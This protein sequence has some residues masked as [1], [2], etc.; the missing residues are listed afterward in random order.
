MSPCLF[1]IYLYQYLLLYILGSLLHIL[2]LWGGLQQLKELIDLH[3]RLM[4]DDTPQHINTLHDE[5]L[6]LTLESIHFIQ[7]S[8]LFTPEIL[9][10]QRCDLI[11]EEHNMMVLHLYRDILEY[12]VDLKII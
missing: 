2:L 9:H 5:G 11:L 3:F 6:V 4:L 1:K 12:L 10:P 7:E 8:Y